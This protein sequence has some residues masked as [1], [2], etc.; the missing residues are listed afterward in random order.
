VSPVVEDGIKSPAV[1]AGPEELCDGCV[2]VLER[3]LDELPEMW[4]NL[5]VSLG[6]KGTN[7]D[8]RVSG[9]RQ[10]PIPIAVEVDASKTAI[11]EWVAAGASRLAE[12]M[13]MDDPT[14]QSM[15]DAEH[16]RSVFN[17]CKLLRTNLS[18]LLSSEPD[19]VMV[20][21]SPKETGRPGESWT[22]SLGKR[23]GT[24]VVDMSGIEIGLELKR[25]HK[26]A[27]MLLGHTQPK[28]RQSLPCPLC[29]AVSCFRIVRTV[30]EKVYD[31]VECEACLKQWTYDRFQQ[32]CDLALEYL[33]EQNVEE[34]ERI[35]L[36]RLRAEVVTLRDFQERAVAAE[37]K[38][39]RLERG[40]LAAAD[41]MFS[42]MSARE[43]ADVVLRDTAA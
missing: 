43:F 18:M 22:D 26:Q 24:K 6:D 17:G 36:E 32:M 28:I 16:G 9:T 40:Y 39:A 21:L 27:R 37:A 15:S 5:H 34:A 35:E 23:R 1:T 25:Q 7:T 4:L 12:A 2:H 41:P 38:A 31:T 42:E 19:S 30:R 10:P 3:V 20:W 11:S 13:G 8:Q 14:P 33:K 29:A